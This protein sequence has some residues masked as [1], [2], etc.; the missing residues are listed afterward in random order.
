MNYFDV[1]LCVIIGLFVIKSVIRGATR[2]IFSLLAFIIAAIVSFRYYP[3]ATGLLPSSISIPW[4]KNSIAFSGIFILVYLGVTLAGWVIAQFLKLI[5]L[6]PVDRLAGVFVGFAKGYLIVCFIIIALLLMLPQGSRLIRD[7]V[8]SS[9]SLP[10]IEKIAQQFPAQFKSIIE[11][12]I[13]ELQKPAPSK[14]PV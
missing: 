4:A 12:R 9:Y 10:V 14:I 6:K 1:I 3:L 5:H 13:R 7:S 11:Q 2:E 8:I